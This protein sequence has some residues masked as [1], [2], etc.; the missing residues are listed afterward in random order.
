MTIIKLLPILTLLITSCA[1]KEVWT[2]DQITEYWTTGKTL[3]SQLLDQFPLPNQLVVDDKGYNVLID[4]AHECSFSTLWTLP[5]Q[6]N[7]I[8]YRAIGSHAT[9]N[10]TIDPDG[11][12][13]IRLVY[14]TVN[15]IYPF[16]WMPNSK[17]QV[18]ITGQNNYDSQIYTEEELSALKEFVK[19]GGGLLVQGKPAKERIL[20]TFDL[21]PLAENGKHEYEKGR[22]WYTGSNGDLRYPN[23][24]TK[25][26]KDSVDHELQSVIE[27]LVNNQKKMDDAPNYPEPMWGGG[28]IY[29]ELEDNFNNIVFYWAANQKKELLETVT[30]DV[31]KAQQFINERLPSK[32]TAEPMYLILCAGSG[33]GWAVNAYKPKENGIISL[34]THGILSIFGHELAHTMRGPTDDEGNVAGVT[35]IPNRGEAHAGWFQGKVNALFKEDLLTESNRNCNSFFTWDPEGNALDLATHYENEVLNKEWGKGKD[36]TKTWYIW[37]KLDDRY[38]PTWY[39]RWKYIQHTRWKDDPEHILSWDEMVEDMSIAVG[40]DLFPFMVKAGTSLEKN[41]LESINFNGEILLL[42]IA[43]IELTPGGPVRIE[44]IG[45][46]RQKLVPIN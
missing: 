19:S 32:P 8:G 16:V 36:W 39:P 34:D 18:I 23:R 14:D 29:P 28:G 5:E 43:P 27:W 20:K 46:Y 45:D 21:D 12:S 42:D 33:G 25:E 35:P 41:R 1:P 15:K 37:Q 17:Y 3:P 11:E 40:E 4:M 24:G 38:G 30:I 10:S 9:I 22:I 44:P 13:R 31:P 26:Q 7:K 2:D 6:L